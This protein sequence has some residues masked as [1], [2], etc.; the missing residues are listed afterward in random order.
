MLMA[1]KP[2]S[3]KK[4][5]KPVYEP[6]MSIIGWLLVALFAWAAVL[7]PCLMPS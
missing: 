2:A 4:G 5:G 3:G 7:I 1:V 6:S